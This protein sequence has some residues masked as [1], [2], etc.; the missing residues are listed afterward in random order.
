MGSI[1]PYI[2]QTTRVS[3]IAHMQ[4]K[5]SISF[6]QRPTNEHGNRK[7]PTV[8]RMIFLYDEN[9]LAS[10][11]NLMEGHIIPDFTV[12]FFCFS[13]PSMKCLDSLAGHTSPPPRAAWAIRGRGWGLSQISNLKVKS[14]GPWNLH[15][16]SDFQIL[17]IIIIISW[18]FTSAWY[19]RHPVV[20]MIYKK[21]WL[22]GHLWQTKE[23]FT[24]KA[25][26]KTSQDEHRKP[27]LFCINCNVT[28]QQV[29]EKTWV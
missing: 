29:P 7:N 26:H 19:T 2:P 12:R 28:L 13:H 24:M 21:T 22:L 4:T 17:I 20:G 11:V 14:K 9:S 1:I 23:S 3:F 16:F 25:L 10:Y 6:I 27:L 15:C 8:W 5:T 18:E